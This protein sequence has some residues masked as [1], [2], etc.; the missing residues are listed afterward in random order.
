MTLLEAVHKTGYVYNDIK[1]HNICF[2]KYS[3]NEEEQDLHDIK[4]IDFGNV[5]KYLDGNNEHLKQEKCYSKG[6]IAF[7]STTSLRDLRTS[8][9]DD[10]LALVYFLYYLLTARIYGTDKIGMQEKEEQDVTNDT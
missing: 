3:E 2:G 10:V 9:R 8:R 6:N 1:P 5:S 7:G 4:L